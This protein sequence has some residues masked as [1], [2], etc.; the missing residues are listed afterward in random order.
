MSHGSDC[1]TLWSR[2]LSWWHPTPQVCSSFERPVAM[3]HW[4]GKGR[5]GTKSMKMATHCRHNFGKQLPDAHVVFYL[6][7]RENEHIGKIFPDRHVLRH[8]DGMAGSLLS[9]PH[10]M[11][12]YHF[13]VT[14]H[15][16]PLF[17]NIITFK[18]I[19]SYYEEPQQASPSAHTTR[20]R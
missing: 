10:A 18:G 20:M 3:Q 1:A 15:F 19:G 17:M 12:D 7:P 14:G 8:M 4:Q 16:E 6:K 9:Y 2:K 5:Q 13:K 11:P